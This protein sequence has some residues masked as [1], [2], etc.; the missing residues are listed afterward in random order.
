MNAIAKK[1]D[2][3][4]MDAARLRSDPYAGVFFS[5]DRVEVIIESV[6]PE[7]WAS[8]ASNGGPG[9]NVRLL[10]AGEWMSG[11]PEGSKFI[12]TFRNLDPAQRL[13]CR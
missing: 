12:D 6:E 4:D 1:S 7:D 13:T 9:G 11:C 8:L 2:D 5:K 3:V 10:T